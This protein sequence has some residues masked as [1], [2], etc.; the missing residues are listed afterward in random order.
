MVG[1]CETLTVSDGSAGISLD[2]LEF[3]W[4]FGTVLEGHCSS[5]TAQPHVATRSPVQIYLKQFSIG[6]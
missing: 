2:L 5:G 6:Q 3:I 4:N 1:Q